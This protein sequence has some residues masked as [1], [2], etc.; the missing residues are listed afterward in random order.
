MNIYLPCFVY[1]L[2]FEPFRTLCNMESSMEMPRVAV[3]MLSFSKSLWYQR[4]AETSITI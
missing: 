4:Y 2:S 3:D 1:L